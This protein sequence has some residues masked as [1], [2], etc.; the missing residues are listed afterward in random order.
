MQLNY[1]INELTKIKMDL[2][3]IILKK[4][5]N[6]KKL[7]IIEEQLKQF[8]GIN[9]CSVDRDKNSFTDTSNDTIKITISMQLGPASLTSINLD[10][11]NWTDSDLKN[12][13]YEN[14]NTFTKNEFQK[15]IDETSTSNC[16]IGAYK[17]SKA[18][19]KLIETGE[20]VPNIKDNTNIET[21]LQ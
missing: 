19:C 13:K 15:I 7:L 21:L 17:D 5:K 16:P 3:Q 20:S 6:V 2:N 10:K 14:L 18:G 1:E 12:S 9:A 11:L 8:N 4:L